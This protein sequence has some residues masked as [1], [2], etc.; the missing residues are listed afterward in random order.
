MVPTTTLTSE[1]DVKGEGDRERGGDRGVIERYETDADGSHDDIDRLLVHLPGQD[2][3]EISKGPA[4]KSNE[5]VSA[6][7]VDLRSFALPNHAALFEHI[8]QLFAIDRK[9]LLRQALVNKWDMSQ[10][11]LR[12][13]IHQSPS[14]DGT[15][16]GTGLE[17]STISISSAS[18]R[19]QLALPAMVALLRLKLY[20]GQGWSTK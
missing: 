16:S 6:S 14:K 13:L 10:P 9:Y 2:T 18:I 17:G 12:H 20:S 19:G 4:A 7:T 15:G 11:H 5:A 8:T 1:S 3:D